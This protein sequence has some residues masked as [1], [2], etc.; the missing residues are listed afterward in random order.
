MKKLVVDGRKI[1]ASD[2]RV[3]LALVFLAWLALDMRW[4]LDLWHKLDLTR[5]RYAGKSWE[6]KHLAAEDGHLFDLMQQFRAKLPITQPR[7]FL[8]AD[9]EYVRGRSAYHL[10]PF[11]VMSGRDLLPARQ[12]KSGDFI[13][14]L[15][16]DEVSFDPLHHL[17]TWK[18]QQQ[19]AADLLLL[20]T[21]NVLLRVR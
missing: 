7:V 14:I 9:E 13:I 19:L 4:Q 12:F 16:K 5:Q 20:A 8:F 11:N 6:E 10:Y 21:N 3:I 17:L 1:L 15:G 2:I 18:P